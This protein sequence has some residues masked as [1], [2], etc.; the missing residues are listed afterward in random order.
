L[1]PGNA[2]Q[3][4]VAS[5]ERIRIELEH[6]ERIEIEETIQRTTAWEQQSPPGNVNPQLFD[7]AAEDEALARSA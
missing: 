6:K 4:L 1:L 3:H 2:A 7:Y 5:S